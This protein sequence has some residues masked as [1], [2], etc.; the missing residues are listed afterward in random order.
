VKKRKGGSEGARASHDER[1]RKRDEARAE[2]VLQLM[3]AQALCADFV[4]SGAREARSC[5]ALV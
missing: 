5:A 4:Q 2:H 1:L 3:D